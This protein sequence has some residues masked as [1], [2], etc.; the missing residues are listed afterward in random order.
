MKITYKK[1]LIEQEETILT[2]NVEIKFES[3]GGIHIYH[4]YFT[5]KGSV[6]IKKLAIDGTSDCNPISITPITSNHIIVS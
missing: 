1:S 2:P 3:G 6:A 4:I 5:T